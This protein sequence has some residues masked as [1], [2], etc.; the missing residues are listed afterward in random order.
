MSQE[1]QE[2]PPQPVPQAG[3][4]GQVDCSGANTLREHS[5]VTNEVAKPELET[6]LVDYRLIEKAVGDLLKIQGVNEDLAKLVAEHLLEA[7]LTG[8]DSHGFIQILRYI[9]YI[10]RGFIDISSIGH[11]EIILAESRSDLT[12]VDGKWR[13]G[14]EVGRFVSDLVAEKARG[15]SHTVAFRN[16]PHMG[17]LGSYAKELASQG[18]MVQMMVTVEGASRVAPH[19][20]AQGY[21]GTNPICFAL[22]RSEGSEPFLMDFGTAYVE[23]KIRVAYTRGLQVDPGILIDA[24]GVPT[25]DP[26]V[27]Y[28]EPKGAILP[29]GM[30]QAHKGGALNLAIF[31]M[32]NLM[33][34]AYLPKDRKVE[35]GSNSGYLTAFDLST[36]LSNR[37]EDGFNWIESQ[38]NAIKSLP[39]AQ[40]ID[41]IFIP[42]EIES[43]NK[44]E[45]MVKGLEVS[46]A[47]IELLDSAAKIIGIDLA[48]LSPELNSIRNA[49]N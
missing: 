8:H 21:L 40:G 10:D 49:M 34:G 29:F 7:N 39:R 17:R 45:R 33:S 4:N 30:N 11:P 14:Q 37:A 25:T 5:L 1:P 28:E 23:G 22:P 31:L 48:T 26:R 27:I 16:S 9:Q 44:V 15:G 12:V 43:R 6:A 47:E 36:V 19:G 41:E 2:A 32:G 13:L 24:N 18:F 46:K 20:A 42:G 35:P 3:S 38:I